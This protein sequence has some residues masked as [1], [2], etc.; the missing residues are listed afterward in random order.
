MSGQTPDSSVCEKNM[1]SCADSF[2][3]LVAE[4]ANERLQNGP[5]QTK[6]ELPDAVREHWAGQFSLTP[7]DLEKLK[8]VEGNLRIFS[9]LLPTTLLKL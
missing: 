4:K 6:L 8:S 5:V 7:L 2:V 3:A 1:P 9:A